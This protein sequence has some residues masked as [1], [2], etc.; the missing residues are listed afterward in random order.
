MALYGFR[1][2]H[3]SAKHIQELH[4]GKSKMWMPMKL[5]LVMPARLIGILR[6]AGHAQ[7]TLKCYTNHQ[8][9]L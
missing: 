2:R 5:E 8:V 9:F 6:G 1:K 7:L 4:V 3:D